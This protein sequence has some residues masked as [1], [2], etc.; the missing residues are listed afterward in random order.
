MTEY[1]KMMSGK[2][3]KLV[4]KFK[5]SY[6]LVL[7]LLASDQGTAFVKNSMIQ[8]DIEAELKEYE[9]VEADLR[10]QLE[11]H[12][13]ANAVTPVEHLE[14]YNECLNEVGFQKNK[15]RKDMEKEIQVLE[16]TYPSIKEDLSMLKEYNIID[17]DYRELLYQKTCSE[18]FLDREFQVVSD[19]LEK[20]GFIDVVTKK[21]T[22]K[23]TLASN[24]REVHGLVFAQFLQENSLDKFSCNQLVAMF[25]C[26][27]NVTVSEDLKTI[28]PPAM[29][30]PIVD[31]F[32]YYQDFESTTQINTGEN[33][34]IHYDL[35]E[36]TARWCSAETAEECKLVLQTLEKE[37]TIFLGEFIKAILKINNIAVE[38]E[39]MAEYL[40]NM[41]LLE[42]LKEIPLKTLKFVATNQSLYI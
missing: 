16:E 30:K 17:I 3:Q 32:E 38:M 37:K 40:G 12:S 36:Y 11:K 2:P 25:S 1:K 14:R 4:S 42:K 6:H 23:G 26:F 35:M 33:Y 24:I 10:D 27:T 15:K 8:Q 5:I 28:K 31:L 34:D 19:F 7:N 29:M 21:P 22:L 9:K 20:D 18:Q 39:K 13:L 41:S